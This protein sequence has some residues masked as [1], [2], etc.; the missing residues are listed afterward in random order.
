VTAF[1]FNGRKESGP[2]TDPLSAVLGGGS[3]SSMAA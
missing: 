1:W 2:P 3:V